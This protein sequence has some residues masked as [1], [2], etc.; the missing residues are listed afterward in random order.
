MPQARGYVNSE[1]RQLFFVLKGLQVETKRGRCWGNGEL[2][3]DSVSWFI[4]VCKQH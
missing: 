1:L 4:A 3:A 2:K